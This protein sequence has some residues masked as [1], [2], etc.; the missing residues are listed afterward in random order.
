MVKTPENVCIELRKG[1]ISYHLVASCKHQH[2][3]QK[4]FQTIVS[5]CVCNLHMNNFQTLSSSCKLASHFCITS[6]IDL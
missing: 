5:V 1:H 6:I 4:S 2:E 3:D